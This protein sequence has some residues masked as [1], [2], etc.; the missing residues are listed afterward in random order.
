MLNNVIVVTGNIASGKS[1]VVKE[2][3]KLFPEAVS[4]SAD[5]IGHEILHSEKGFKLMQTHPWPTG[6][7]T[8][9]ETPDGVLKLMGI[10]RKYLSNLVFNTPYY[11]EML[12]DILHPEINY[13]IM[14]I[15]NEAIAEDKKVILEHPLLFANGLENLFSNILYVYAPVQE[16]L[17]RLTGFRGLSERDSWARINSQ[18]TLEKDEINKKCRFTLDTSFLD[19]DKTL[20]E[21]DFWE[22]YTYVLASSAGDIELYKTEESAIKGATLFR[23]S[24][25]GEWEEGSEKGYSWV[26]EG[27]DEDYE[28]LVLWIDKYNVHEM[29]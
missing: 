6:V 21:F 28:D 4:I 29:K 10:D 7:Y 15:I 18:R 14:Q 8:Y 12:N 25:E 1:T 3:E 11:R 13:K 24:L 16:R 2:L 20:Q 22:D 27:E 26:F 9:E 17:K 19:W 5:K 23:E